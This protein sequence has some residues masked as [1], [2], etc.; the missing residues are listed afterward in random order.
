MMGRENQRQNIKTFLQQNVS[1]ITWSEEV[2]H[3]TEQLIEKFDNKRE[4][5]KAVDQLRQVLKLK[6]FVVGE[7]NDD[8][9]CGSLTDAQLKITEEE[10]R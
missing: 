4:S 7:K 9:F 2:K 5:W 8:V 10:Q 1:K 6:N 3:A